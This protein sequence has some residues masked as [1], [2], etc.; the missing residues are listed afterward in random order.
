MKASV[1]EL[2][3]QLQEQP[4]NAELY[5]RL[6]LAL[7][8]KYPG[9]SLQEDHGT[10]QTWNFKGMDEMEKATELD[11]MNYEYMHTCALFREKRDD[12]DWALRGFKRCA[13][14]NPG[15]EGLFEDIKRV[16]DKKAAAKQQQLIRAQEEVNKKPQDANALRMMGYAFD[17]EGKIEEALV[18]YQK[19]IEADPKDDT[20][21]V[22]MAATFFKAKRYQESIEANLKAIELFVPFPPDEDD[23][24][25]PDYAPD[26][27]ANI[28]L[29]IA[30]C[31]MELKDYDHAEEYYR[32]TFEIE[33]TYDGLNVYLA[34]IE[35]ARERYQEALALYLEAIEEIDLKRW[36]YIEENVGLCYIHLNDLEN[37]KRWLEKC[38]KRN[39]GYSGA[40]YNLAV[41]FDRLGDEEGTE[42]VLQMA[43]QAK[44]NDIKALYQL[45][46]I[47]KNK[48]YYRD[49]LELLEKAL[50]VNPFEPMVLE[51]RA[52][53]YA[54]MGDSERAEMEAAM[55]QFVKDIR[56]GKEPDLGDEEDE[57][58]EEDEDDDEW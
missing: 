44:Q 11:P 19:A 17:N 45:A 13:E 5:Y 40:Y 2:Q 43:V 25:D 32:K 23:L 41:V 3:A 35:Y 29:S 55:A 36:S 8:E 38:I 33:P 46:K 28:H 49:A 30:E 42:M 27:T 6:G 21:Y 7:Q 20:V 53:I 54:N 12:L 47:Y 39:P 18:W 48:G 9:H 26:N 31:Y 51:M 56:D 24:N 16:Q 34:E 10:Y 37:A 1:E 50:Y 52:E 15:A 57:E 4:E 14:L 22:M 58:G